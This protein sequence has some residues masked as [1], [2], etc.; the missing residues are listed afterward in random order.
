MIAD[1]APG[2]RQDAGLD[3]MKH[4]INKGRTKMLTYKDYL[5]EPKRLTFDEMV[6]LHETIAYTRKRI[7]DLA[8]FLVFIES[9]N[10]R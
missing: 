7:G 2:I 8:C 4:H 9:L 6:R 10:A 5:Q 1:R 3:V